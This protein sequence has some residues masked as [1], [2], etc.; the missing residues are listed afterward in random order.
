[1][2]QNNFLSPTGEIKLS[3]KE[4]IESPEMKEIAAK[5]IETHKIEL[6]PAQIGYLLV[7][8]NISKQR[9][10]K[11]MK[12]TNEVKHYSGNDYLIEVSG[13]LWDMLDTD[14]KKM[15]LYHE[16]LHVDPVFTAK[17]Q[18]WKMN[19]R[20]PDFADYYEI[21][22]KFGNEWYKTIQATVSSL[23]DLDPRQE[24]K[25]SV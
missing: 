18:E 8:P 4:L 24:S 6:G 13:D 1:M 21:N 14:T 19:L 3:G 16:L 20:K 7:Y 10:A 12:S 5:V 15:L 17:N 11:C 22:D 9:A 2:E 25:V 23:H